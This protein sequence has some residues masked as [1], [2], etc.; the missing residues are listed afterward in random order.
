MNDVWMSN[1][2]I[3]ANV[4]R[5]LR[6]INANRLIDSKKAKRLLETTVNTFKNERTRITPNF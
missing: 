3:P 6:H 1:R 5:V 2:L 4:L